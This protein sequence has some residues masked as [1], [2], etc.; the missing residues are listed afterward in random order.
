MTGTFRKRP[1]PKPHKFYPILSR[2][3]GDCEH[4]DYCNDCM[5]KFAAQAENERPSHVW[6]VDDGKIIY[7]EDDLMEHRLGRKLKP[8][9]TVIHKNG[10]AKDNRDANLALVT[11]DNLESEL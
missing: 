8:N 4:C 10:N 5:E 6:R 11:I 7:M 9:E 2:S 3:H 1:R